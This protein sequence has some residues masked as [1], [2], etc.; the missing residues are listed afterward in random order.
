MKEIKARAL[1]KIKPGKLV[2]FKALIAKFIAAVKGNEPG[3]LQYRWYLNEEAME[4]VV[5]EDYVDSD[6]V[7]AHAG[8]VGPLLQESAGLA[9]L[10]LEVYGNPSEQLLKA[11][12]GMHIKM[13]SFHSGI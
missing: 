7:L 10:S 12:E 13:Y 3:N 1:F 4:C 5:L 6:A 9:D 8:N 11:I 2:E